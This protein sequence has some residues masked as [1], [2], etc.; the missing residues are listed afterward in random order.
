MAERGYDY[1][2]ARPDAEDEYLRLHRKFADDTLIPRTDSWWTGTNVKGKG[3][4]LLSWCAGFPEYQKVCQAET[5][6]DYPGFVLRSRP[7][8]AAR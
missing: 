2:D 6:G 3:R 8:A 5:G 4:T 7:A 1:I